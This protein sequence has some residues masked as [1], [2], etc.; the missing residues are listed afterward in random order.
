MPSRIPASKSGQSSRA[1]MCAPDAR[2]GRLRPSP[3]GRRGCRSTDKGGNL[4]Y[5]ITWY[6]RNTKTLW[7]KPGSRPASPTRAASFT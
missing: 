1:A 5:D 6:D 3:S 7:F 4:M 2:G